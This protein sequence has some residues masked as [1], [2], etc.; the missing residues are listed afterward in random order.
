MLSTQLY[1]APAPSAYHGLQS[2]HYMPSAAFARGLDLESLKSKHHKKHHHKHKHGK[3]SKK[4]DK[5]EK[6]DKKEEKEEKDP[7][8]DKEEEDSE[9]YFFDEVMGDYAESHGPMAYP[10][11]PMFAHQHFD[12][13]EHIPVHAHYMPHM[14][15]YEGFHMDAH[16]DDDHHD[17][18]HHDMY[19]EPV[20]QDLFFHIEEPPKE[21]KKPEEPKPKKHK[22]HHD[23]KIIITID[24]G[25]EE[26]DKKDEEDEKKKKEEEEKNK[27]KITNTDQ[28]LIVHPE[29]GHHDHHEAN[30]DW[31]FADQDAYQHLYP[32]DIH[33]SHFV[34]DDF[35][36]GDW[37][38]HG[39][40]A[41]HAAAHY[42]H[43]Y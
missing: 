11:Y 18:D 1:R 20:E 27:P 26:A 21:E 38:F 35:H 7:K 3:K 2:L 39:H 22:R 23:R 12:I 9:P 37:G 40:V 28:V 24:D 34:A 5:K 17:Y 13:P 25:D 33:N 30:H 14:H 19:D 41:P 10:H 16:H 31:G 15:E 36:H 43:F 42:G 32:E 4:E 6:K 29:Y 8:E